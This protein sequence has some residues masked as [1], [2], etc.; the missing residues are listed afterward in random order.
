MQTNKTNKCPE[1]EGTGKVEVEDKYRVHSQI[2]D[3]PYRKVECS[4]CDG[5]GEVGDTED[6]ILKERKMK[7]RQ[8]F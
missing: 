6:E 5:T 8:Q 3:V 2:T 7:W 4:K 1:C